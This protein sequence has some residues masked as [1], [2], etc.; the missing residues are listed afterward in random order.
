[1]ATTIGKLNFLVGADSSGVRTGLLPGM[2]AIQGVQATVARMAGQLTVLFGGMTAAGAAGWAVK[3]A[4][5]AENAAIKFEVLIGSASAAR[6]TLEQLQ[7]LDVKTPFDYQQ[8]RDGAEQLLIYGVNAQA[9]V[10]MLSMLSDISAGNAERL[11]RLSY[12]LGQ[13][14]Q[15]GRLTGMELR[16]MTEAGFS[17]LEMIAKRTG[18][19]MGE[20]RARMSAGGISI[21]EVVKA[22]EDATSEGGRFY[23]LS[24][25]MSQTLEGRWSSL[26]STGKLLATEIGEKMMPALKSLTEVGIGA[27]DWVRNLDAGT[28]KS[29]VSILAMT[30]AFAGA[31]A[32]VPRI[33]TA[34]LAIVKT[35]RAIAIGQSIAQ[36]LGGPAGWAALAA[37]LV[38]AAAAGVAVNAMFDDVSA[39]SGKATQSV[40]DTRKEISNLFAGG[41]AGFD[42]QPL[43]EKLKS[44]T[45][46]AKEVK[47]HFSDARKAIEGTRGNFTSAAIR[48]TSEG[49]MALA[50]A[51]RESLIQKELQRLNEMEQAALKRIE[52]ATMEVKA[53]IE[54]KEPIEVEEVRI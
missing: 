21:R 27:I 53:A 48:G 45:E 30:G 31:I 39:A 43:K 40:R 44:L 12:A 23:N 50:N 54:K 47:K 16:Q 20:L 13:V 37:G 7:A 4:A 1:M 52:Q 2:A 22:M 3:L 51:S 35:L 15:L 29:T 6:Q 9:V 10:P 17:P 42:V 5:S 24:D 33:V 11:G 41:D 25:R 46:E 14:N 28:V 32:I 34:G 18:E 49:I 8:L 38:A 36:A 26:V 19:T